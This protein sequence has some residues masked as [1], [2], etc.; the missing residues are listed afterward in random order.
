MHMLLH[1]PSYGIKRATGF[2]GLSVVRRA[3]NIH[4]FIHVADILCTRR[5]RSIL[6][7]AARSGKKVTLRSTHPSRLPREP[8]G[9]CAMAGPEDVM[10]AV[11][12]FNGFD[13]NALDTL[14]LHG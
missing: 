3:V 13:T 2:A 10:P 4:S 7:L 11:T 8:S 6:G 12:P 9:P 14:A 1:D 5:L